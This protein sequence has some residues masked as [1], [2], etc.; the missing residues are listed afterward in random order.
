MIEKERRSVLGNIKVA[1]SGQVYLVKLDVHI[2]L[3][4][5]QTENLCG[6]FSWNMDLKIVHIMDD[7]IYGNYNTKIL[8]IH[9]K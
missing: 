1:S 2:P 3:N 9:K 6:R 5:T 8:N 7:E 4:G